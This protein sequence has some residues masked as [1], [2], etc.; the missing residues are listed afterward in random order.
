MFQVARTSDTEWD[1]ALDATTIWKSGDD[2]VGTWSPHSYSGWAHV[3]SLDGWECLRVSDPLGNPI[4]QVLIKKRGPVRIAY[5]P[6]GF[7]ANQAVNAN[8]FTRF[9]QTTLDN[10]LIYV[11]VHCLTPAKYGDASMRRAGWRTTAATLGA[12]ISLELRLDLSIEA[13]TEALTSNWHRNLR[14]AEKHGNTV[15]IDSTPSAESIAILH[16]ELK[17][18][19]GTHVNTWESSQPHVERLIAGFGTRLI[20]AKCVSD[21]GVLRAIRGVIITGGCAFDILAAAS[22]EGRKHYSSHIT[23]WTLANELAARGVVRYDLGGID[24]EQNRGVYDFKHGTGAVG[25]TYGG[26]HD[27][28]IPL[29]TRWAIG[30][31]TTLGRAV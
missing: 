15:S 20:V 4:T 24:P 27:F 2:R 3:K 1:T 12:R 25:I 8:D 21:Q 16:K 29:C 28:A 7:V 10:R 5:C 30:R 22:M 11:R 14:R 18:L 19:K 26:E 31:L 6:G 9:L 13:R 23:L 17:Q